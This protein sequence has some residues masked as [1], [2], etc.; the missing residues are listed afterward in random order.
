MGLGVGIVGKGDGGVVWD[1]GGLC[2]D[3]EY[4]GGGDCGG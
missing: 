1:V 3:W 2:C 4:I